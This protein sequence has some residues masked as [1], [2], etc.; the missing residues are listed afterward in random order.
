MAA[1]LYSNLHLGFLSNVPCIHGLNCILLSSQQAKKKGKNNAN[2]IKKLS[3]KLDCISTIVI[4]V[5]LKLQ[6]SYCLFSFKG[7]VQRRVHDAIYLQR[8]LQWVKYISKKNLIWGFC[9][10]HC[11]TVGQV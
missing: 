7:A 11:N 10:L 5:I 9:N 6:N 4:I 1:F 8:I 2:L 3:Q